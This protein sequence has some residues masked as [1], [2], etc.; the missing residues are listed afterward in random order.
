MDKICKN[1]EMIV[2]AFSQRKKSSAVW[3]LSVYVKKLDKPISVKCFLKDVFFDSN[4]IVKPSLG[5]IIFRYQPVENIVLIISC[6]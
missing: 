1:I 6:L 4:K 2:V 3:A 5:L